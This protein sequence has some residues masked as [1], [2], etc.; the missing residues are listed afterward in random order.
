MIKQG[1]RE[2]GEKAGMMSVRRGS[3]NAR[4]GGSG[5]DG[6]GRSG[7][8]GVEGEEMPYPS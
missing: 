8:G 4:G 5:G 2:E 6:K 7:R 1:A 3:G